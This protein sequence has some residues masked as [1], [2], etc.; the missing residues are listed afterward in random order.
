MN[1]RE[2]LEKF[3]QFP[4]TIISDSL[5]RMNVMDAGIKPLSEDLHLIGFARPVKTMVGD[6]LIIHQAIYECE[7]YDVL[8]VDARSHI[9]TAVLGLLQVKSSI[10]Q[11]IS[12]IVIDG[13]IRDSLEIKKSKFPVFC[14]GIT[15][16][17]PHKGWGGVL[18]EPIACGNVAVYKGDL[19][20]GDYDGVVVIPQSRIE[21]VLEKSKKNLEKEKIWFER[22]E[23]GEKT[24]DI[25]ELP[26]KI[27]KL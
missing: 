4:T 12:G 3:S 9:N 11:K 1:R 18:D 19:I 7:E 16:A 10:K 5:G 6:N 13:A 14:R 25:L 21:E 22:L 27:K 17:G 15:S 20:V 24:T 26:S 8:V 23:S 2:I